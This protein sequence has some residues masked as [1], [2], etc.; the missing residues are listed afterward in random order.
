MKLKLVTAPT[1]EP[2]TLAQLKLH[3]RLDSLAFA[4]DITTYQSVPPGSHG[5]AAAYSLIGSTVDVAGKIG[6]V[7]LNSGANGS[8]GKVDV[9]IQESDDATTYTDWYAFTQIAESNDNL[10]YEKEYTGLKRYLRVVC[11]V[12]TSACEFAVDVI[13]KSGVADEDTWLTNA[14]TMVREYGE[15]YTQQAFVPQTWDVYLDDFPVADCI[16]WPKGPLTS[17]TGVYYRDTEGTETEMV[18]T[19]SYLVSV[20]A[21]PGSIFLPYGGCWPYQPLFPYNAI[22]LRGVCGYTGTAPYVIPKN[23]YQAMLL[24]AGLLYKYR[25][26]DL[27]PKQSLDVVHNLYDMDRYAW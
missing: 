27:I 23:F 7:N 5:V 18:L 12:A 9:K 24:H 25:E 2:V 4:D 20:D 21:I 14:I 16:V 17:L 6:I 3:L 22:R 8:G 10:V 11:T 26:S 19:S 1:T 15:K 13:A